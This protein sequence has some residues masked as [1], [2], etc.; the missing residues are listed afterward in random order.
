MLMQ[1]ALLAM[2]HQKPEKKQVPASKP[3]AVVRVSNTHRARMSW[4]AQGQLTANGERFNPN[5]LT[6]AHK[7]LK[8]GTRLRITR[9]GKSIVVRVNDRG[10]FVS[11]REIDLSRAAFAR[12]ASLDS[13]VITAEVATVK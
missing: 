11:G 1:L 4:Y 2:L 5:A 8:F 6:C 3:A 10:P 12:L 9:N 13:G 7:T